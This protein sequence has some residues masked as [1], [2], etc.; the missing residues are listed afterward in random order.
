MWQLSSTELKDFTACDVKTTNVNQNKQM[1]KNVVNTCSLKD[2]TPQVA[3]ATIVSLIEVKV[4]KSSLSKAK[5]TS[6]FRTRCKKR[7]RF[8]DEQKLADSFCD[9]FL[10][11]FRFLS[12]CTSTVRTAISKSKSVFI[13]W[14]LFYSNEAL[15]LSEKHLF[16]LNLLTLP[17]CT[18]LS[19]CSHS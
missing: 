16:L 5:K 14:T 9:R 19:F 7:V 13:V 11:F 4:A 18:K 3:D 1:T 17:N 8:L 12:S 15:F 10:R 2:E 6:I